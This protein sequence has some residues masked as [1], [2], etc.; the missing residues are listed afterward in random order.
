MTFPTDIFIIDDIQISDANAVLT[1]DTRSLQFRARKIPGQRWE[2]K[3]KTRALP[4]NRKAAMGYAATLGGGVNTD[5]IVLPY[6]SESLAGNKLTNQGIAIGATSANLQESA[7]VNVGDYFKF[8]GHSKVY[9]VK[10]KSGLQIDFHPNLVRAVA[11]SEQLIFNNVPMTVQS[12]QKTQV[13]SS[14]GIRYPLD[15]DFNFVEVIS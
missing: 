15:I 8:A 2:V 11:S 13:F 7:G 12:L 3:L 4:V 10:G 6:F 5:T 14:S 1:N 9:I